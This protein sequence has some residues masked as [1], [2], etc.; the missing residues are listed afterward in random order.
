M[1][2]LATQLDLLDV[3]EQRR[4]TVSSRCRNAH[5][6]EQPEFKVSSAIAWRAALFLIIFGLSF[7]A[8]FF[9]MAFAF[10]VDVRF[11]FL[12][13]SRYRWQRHSLSVTSRCDVTRESIVLLIMTSQDITTKWQPKTD[14]RQALY[15]I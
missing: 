2:P 7:V 1:E 6:S 9:V 15:L 8:F 3:R 5:S 10:Q 13:F 12:D 4:E 11:C 14:Q